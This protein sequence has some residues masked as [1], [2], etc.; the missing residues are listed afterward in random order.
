MEKLNAINSK[1]IKDIFNASYRKRDKVS[2]FGQTIDT[3]NLRNTQDP[4]LIDTLDIL[5]DLYD[6]ALEVYDMTSYPMHDLEGT[7][8]SFI[9]D[10]EEIDHVNTYNWSAPLTNDLDF[11][12]YK[13]NERIYFLLSV[14]N[15]YSDARCGYTV[16]FLFIFENHYSNED[17]V[18]LFMELPSANKYFN[19]GDWGFDFNICYESGVFNVHKLDKTFEEYEVYM[20]NYEDCEKYIQ[21]IEVELI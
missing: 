20:G 13:D 2:Q 9:H 5:T 3:P 7:N 6:E 17:W 18:V 10:L 16:E 11:K 19:I 8:F 12:I 4:T 15:G 14:Q 21:N 1:D